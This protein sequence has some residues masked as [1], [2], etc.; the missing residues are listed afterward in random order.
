MVAAAAALATGVALLRFMPRLDS[1]FTN[2]DRRIYVLLFVTL[3][4]SLFAALGVIQLFRWSARRAFLDERRDPV[5][6]ARVVRLPEQP[7]NNQ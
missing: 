4:G 6:D 7:N 5:P 3:F 2:E 1:V